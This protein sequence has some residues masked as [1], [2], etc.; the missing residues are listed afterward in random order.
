MRAIAAPPPDHIEPPAG[1]AMSARAQTTS[2]RAISPSTA[3]EFRGSPQ[4]PCKST[5]GAGSGAAGTA[6]APRTVSPER[7]GRGVMPSPIAASADVRQVAPNTTPNST[8]R[9]TVVISH[10]SRAPSEVGA[11]S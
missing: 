1:Q 3:H 2:P 8:R 10:L 9:Q 6:S 4:M 5:I 11:S 7:L